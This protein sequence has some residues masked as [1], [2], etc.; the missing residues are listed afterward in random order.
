MNSVSILF[1]V[2]KVTVLG[3][4]SIVPVVSNVVKAVK[5]WRADVR[6]IR[7]KRRS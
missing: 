7:T 4:E 1:Q 5:K 6:E 2:I 3:I